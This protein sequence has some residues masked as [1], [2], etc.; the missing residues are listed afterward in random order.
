MTLVSIIF[1]HE[2]EAERLLGSPIDP[3]LFSD[4]NLGRVLDKLFDTGAQAIYS[5]FK[6]NASD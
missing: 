3:E 2:K 1:F 6:E 5:L 4:H